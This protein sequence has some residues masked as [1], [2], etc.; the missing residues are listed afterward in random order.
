MRSPPG[1]ASPGLIKAR[2]STLREFKLSAGALRVVSTPRSESFDSVNL[3]NKFS[4]SNQ[5]KK[6]G[7]PS[8]PRYTVELGFSYLTSNFDVAKGKYQPPTMP[9]QQLRGS[10]WQS[11]RDKW[12]KNRNHANNKWLKK[13]DIMDNRDVG[14]EPTDKYDDGSADSVA[15]MLTERSFLVKYDESFQPYGSTLAA[16]SAELANDELRLEGKPNTKQ[17]VFHGCLIQEFSSLSSER[18][19]WE[20]PSKSI[21]GNLNMAKGEEMKEQEQD[22][23]PVDEEPYD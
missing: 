12:L 19:D 10:A 2:T 8:D 21:F 9:H 22:I 4:N 3:I 7:Q 5:T 1:I 11:H 23:K 20:P 15:G 13:L 16:I 18:S 14:L 6:A 17:K